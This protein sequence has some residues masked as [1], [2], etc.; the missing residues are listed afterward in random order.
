MMLHVYG[1]ATEPAMYIHSYHTHLYNRSATSAVLI[2]ARATATATHQVTKHKRLL[3][4]LLIAAVVMI[5]AAV[6]I[7]AAA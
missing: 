6:A 7:M 2:K 1:E 3:K 5:A 4:Y